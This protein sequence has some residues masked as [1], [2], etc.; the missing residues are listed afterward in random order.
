M[1]PA[2]PKNKNKRRRSRT[3][4]SPN[5]SAKKAAKKV[6]ELSQELS[7]IIDRLG[8]GSTHENELEKSG[9]PGEP[10]ISSSQI[11]NSSK[12][13]FREKPMKCKV[14]VY[15]NSRQILQLLL[16]RKK[17]VQKSLIP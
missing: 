17:G 16:L 1:N 3:S 12:T 14:W 4:L 11:S 9:V 5:K 8:D 15:L 7:S 10:I 13:S 6:L 2:S